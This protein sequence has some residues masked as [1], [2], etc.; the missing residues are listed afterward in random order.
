MLLLPLCYYLQELISQ[1]RQLSVR[2][3]SPVNR[4]L[5][6]KLTRFTKRCYALNFARMDQLPRVFAGGINVGA[7]VI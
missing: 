1:A 5:V 2:S 6:V 4:F 3:K 7:P